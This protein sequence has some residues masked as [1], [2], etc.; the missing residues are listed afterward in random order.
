MY[1]A[2]LSE[3]GGDHLAV[4]RKNERD[5]QLNWRY[6]DKSY[7]ELFK[8]WRK[9]SKDSHGFYYVDKSNELTYR[10]GYGFVKNYPEAAESNA[11]RHVY[12]IIGVTMLLIAAVDIIRLYISPLILSRLG[13]DVYYDYFTG[14]FYGNEWLITL[15][16]LFFE[17]FKR[18]LPLMYCYKKLKMPLKVMIPTNI[19]NRPLFRAAI[20]ISLLASGVC[21]ALSAIYKVILG[22]AGLDSMQGIHLPK[23]PV[24]FAVAIIINVAIIPVA[25][26]IYTRGTIMQ[27]LRQFGDGFAIIVTS[28]LT[29]MAAYDIK[30]FCYVFVTSV[31]IGYFT[32][33]T[34][35]VITAVVMRIVSKAFIY[36]VYCLDEYIGGEL[37]GIL[38]MML[39]F[40][41]I[42]TGLM[43]LV[44]FMRKHS[45]KLGMSLKPRY[46]SLSRK[47]LSALTNIPV[48]IGTTVMIIITIINIKFNL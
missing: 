5:D 10:D 28:V 36:L 7:N 46:L 9:Q 14:E 33:R 38:I 30:Q 20:P 48:V 34:G 35:S 8:K 18:F 26:E 12:S 42:M 13:A 16:Y 11:L 41:S 15:M 37:S 2:D 24:V 47:A 21:I 3:K 43:V 25:S 27:L 17:L 44:G 22:N 4:S 45:D 39:L 19:N 6:Q 32:L 29:A 31:V 23:D 1:I 40:L